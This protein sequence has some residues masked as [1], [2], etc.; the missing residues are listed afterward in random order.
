MWKSAGL[1]RLLDQVLHLGDVLFGDFDAGAGGRF[2][3]DGKLPGVRSREKGQPQ[4]GIHAEAGHEQEGQPSHRKG[5][6]L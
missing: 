6:P 5:R 2:E 3:V 4:H 1:H